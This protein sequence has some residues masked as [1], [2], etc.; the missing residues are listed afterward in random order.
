MHGMWGFQHSIFSVIF[1]INVFTLV[2]TCFVHKQAVRHKKTLLVKKKVL[3]VT[4]L[5]FKWQPT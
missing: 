3:S 2:D 5:Q 1:I 4:E